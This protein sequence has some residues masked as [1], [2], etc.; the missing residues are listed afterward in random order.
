MIIL[1]PQINSGE[2]STLEECPSILFD[3]WIKADVDHFKCQIEMFESMKTE[4]QDVVTL[5]LH[6]FARR[7]HYQSK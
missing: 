1:K 4:F 6:H 3:V 2:A 7:N 5:K